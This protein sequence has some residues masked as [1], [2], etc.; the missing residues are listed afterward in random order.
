MRIPVFG[1]VFVAGVAFS[2]AQAAPAVSAEGRWFLDSCPPASAAKAHETRHEI[3]HAAPGSSVFVPHPFPQGEFQV[4]EDLK[5]QF[6]DGWSQH[7][8]TD[9]P[10]GV[11]RT[12]EALEEG[13]ARFEVL[14]VTEWRPSRCGFVY[15]QSDFR[16]LVRVRSSS[17]GEELARVS[18]NDSGLLSTFIT[19]EANSSGGELPAIESIDGLREKSAAAA[20]GTD[21]Q[22]VAIAGMSMACGELLP[23]IAFRRSGRALV[24]KNEH[25]FAL[26]VA[27]PGVAGVASHDVAAGTPRG[28]AAVEILRPGEHLITVGA[29][30]FAVATPVSSET[31]KP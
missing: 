16:Y 12:V 20:Q 6:L 5:Y 13:T 15:G 2:V 7:A 25:L 19:A 23:C 3:V 10:G 1:L 31:G 17:T 30:G 27:R 29:D 11:R 14:E 18:L 4:I 9:I 8:R 28:H 24:A 21:F 22:Y 26:D